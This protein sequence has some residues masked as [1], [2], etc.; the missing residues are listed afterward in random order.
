MSAGDIRAN[1][2]FADD[3]GG[4]AFG[5]ISEQ[6]RLAGKAC[7][8]GRLDIPGGPRQIVVTAMVCA[9]SLT[10]RSRAK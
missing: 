6:R 10:R 7:A 4:V 8:A 5:E 9:L 2:S 3:L 1:R